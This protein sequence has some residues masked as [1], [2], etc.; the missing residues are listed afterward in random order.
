MK[1]IPAIVLVCFAALLTGCE[2]KVRTEAALQ[3]MTPY[4]GEENSEDAPGL[5]GMPE[6]GQGTIYF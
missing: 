3:P 1:R 6:D 4:S 2:A 5:E